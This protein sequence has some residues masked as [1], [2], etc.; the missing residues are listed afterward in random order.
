MQRFFVIF[1]HITH[2][3]NFPIFQTEIFVFLTI[4][5]GACKMIVELTTSQIINDKFETDKFA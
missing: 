3:W 4:K 1:Q 5:C 2:F